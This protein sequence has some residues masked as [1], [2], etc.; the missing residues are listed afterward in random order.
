VPAAAAHP[1]QMRAA[2]LLDLPIL[3]IVP[4]VVFLGLAAGYHTSRL[5]RAGT[6]LTVATVLGGGYLLAGD[7]VVQA[8][9]QHPGGAAVADSFTRSGVVSGIAVW[10]LAGHVV[11]FAVLAVAAWRN[12]T[13]PRWAAVSLAVWPL[14]EMGGA[15]AGIKPVA[16][17]GDAL[18]VVACAAALRTL[19]GA[20]GRPEPV[21]V[22]AGNRAVA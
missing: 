12:R 7:V 9:A 6:V 4:A 18:L 3:L 15:A 8:A 14:L 1:A 19:S 11:G 2:L 10:Y 13:L 17:L 21:L 22:T 20:A 16:A 5:A